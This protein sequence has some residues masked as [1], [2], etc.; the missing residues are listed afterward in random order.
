M[1]LIFCIR[2]RVLYNYYMTTTLKFSPE[3]LAQYRLTARSRQDERIFEVRPRMEKGWAL[4]RAAAEVL[5][6]QYY[7]QRVVVFGSL[8]HEER[9]TQWSDVDIAAWG[10][11]PDQTFRAIGAVMDMDLSITVN[12]VDVNTCSLSLLG[13]IE[14]E[15]ADL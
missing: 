4:A 2:C 15:A 11:P 12:L 3:E 6:K 9:F 1:F 7:A 13:A 14:Q 8:L 10:I 5:R